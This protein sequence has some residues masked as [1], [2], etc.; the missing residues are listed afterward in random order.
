MKVNGFYSKLAFE[1]EMANFCIRNQ[2]MS[3][4]HSNIIYQ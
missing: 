1:Y 3:L 4:D 2:H